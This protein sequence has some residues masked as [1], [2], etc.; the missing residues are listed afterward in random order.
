VISDCF[1]YFFRDL[2]AF[3]KWP[4]RKFAKLSKISWKF[5]KFWNRISVDQIQSGREGEPLE[6]E[7]NRILGSKREDRFS[8]HFFDLV[9]N[10]CSVRFSYLLR[11]S[12]FCKAPRDMRKFPQK[13]QKIAGYWDSAVYGSRPQ[14][15][16]KP[17]SSPPE[18]SG[19]DN[20]TSQPWS[21]AT[22]PCTPFRSAYIRFVTI[23][24]LGKTRQSTRS[25]GTGAS[26]VRP[27]LTRD[28]V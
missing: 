24:L 16:S 4:P 8:D 17:D 1:N 12:I 3:R 27:W 15:A 13:C 5:W 23:L 7:I 26:Y 11:L 25:D 9:Q 14:I 10:I 22:C 21:D 6:N 2:H 28:I 18:R 19:L 20:I